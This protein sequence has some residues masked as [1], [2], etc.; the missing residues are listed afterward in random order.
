MKALT[1]TARV[2]LATTF[3]AFAVACGPHY[4]HTD[5]GEVGGNQLPAS[6]TTQQIAV[7]VG[8]VVTAQIT[9]YDSNG[10][11][12]PGDVVSEDATIMKVY[13]AS[14]DRKFAF[15]GVAEGTTRVEIRANGVT[16]GTITAT[17]NPQP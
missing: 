4:S 10:V 3:A 13:H 8:G 16:V 9:P 17:V 11:E 5:F 15:L 14:G 1:V 2:A 6:V 12:M 7:E